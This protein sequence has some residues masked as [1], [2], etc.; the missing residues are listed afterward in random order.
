MQNNRSLQASRAPCNPAGSDGKG[1]Y[2]DLPHDAVVMAQ[3]E[4]RNRH[5][6]RERRMPQPGPENLH[7]Q[8]AERILFCR[9]LNRHNHR[10]NQQ[11][12]PQVPG[13]AVPGG[14]SACGSGAAW[15]QQADGV[16]RQEEEGSQGQG[17]REEFPAQPA[18]G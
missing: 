16:G 18:C 14:G 13:P 2:I 8:P 3:D 7:R 10:D 5:Q 12:E 6:D 1:S 17:F 9:R 15:H 11:Q 4:Q